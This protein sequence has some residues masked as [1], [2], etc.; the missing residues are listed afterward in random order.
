MTSEGA[1]ITSKM[2]DGRSIAYNKSNTDS[3]IFFRVNCNLT[4]KLIADL[5]FSNNDK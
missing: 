4:S 5:T 3:E 1:T 2:A